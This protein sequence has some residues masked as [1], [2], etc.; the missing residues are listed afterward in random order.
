ML[1]LCKY[2][3]YS[4]FE[5]GEDANRTKLYQ[6]EE[7]R[8]KLKSDYTYK[9]YLKNLSLEMTFSNGKDFD[10]KRLVQM[11]QKT[12]QFNLTV[13]RQSEVQLKNKLLSKNYL[14]YAFS[15]KDKFGDYG[16]VGLSQIKI[17]NKKE[18]LIEN[19][20]MSCRVMGRNA[21]QTFLNEIIIDLK[22]QNYNKIYG[23]FSKGLKNQVVKKFYY[24]NG[25]KKI[26]D[27]KRFDYNGE[28]YIYKNK[29]I[30]DKLKVIKINH[31]WEVKKNFFKNCWY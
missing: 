10:F 1:K 18:V 24:E 25:F 28:L 7:K 23:V 4:S 15:L 6:D 29:N 22:K 17:L 11:T 20:L 2:F 21:E 9:D 3:S 5:T 26:N 8:N 27:K 12:N 14:I 13:L 19:L 31:G 30:I 16:T